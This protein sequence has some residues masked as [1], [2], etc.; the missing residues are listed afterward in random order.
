MGPTR[1][2]ECY[3]GDNLEAARDLFRVCE[4]GLRFLQTTPFGKLVETDLDTLR[5]LVVNVLALGEIFLVER[6]VCPHCGYTMHGPGGCIARALGP[7][8]RNKEQV[9][10]IVG[11]LA[12]VKLN[13]PISGKPY[14]EEIAWWVEP[15]HQGMGS[16]RM[17]LE[18]AEAWARENGCSMVKMVAP[19]GSDVGHFYEKQGYVVVETAYQ[20][21]LT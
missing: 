4:M 12:I 5:T 2:R 3:R 15:E 20:K 17:L 1:I 21:D 9:E 19:A 7:E 18:R 14:A 6:W 8:H 16:G 10:P 13:H 11:M